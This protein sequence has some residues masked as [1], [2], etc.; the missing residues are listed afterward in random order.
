MSSSG[1]AIGGDHRGDPNR[2]PVECL[3]LM[4]D[5]LLAQSAIERRSLRPRSSFSK[6]SRF[7]AVRSRVSA[8][9]TRDRNSAI[10]RGRR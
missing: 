4:A 9:L 5:P 10:I 7:G 1:R 3:G 8:P 6:A 2:E